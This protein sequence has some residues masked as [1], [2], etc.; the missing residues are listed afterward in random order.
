[1][2]VRRRNF[3]EKVIASL[4]VFVLVFTNFATL[5]SGLV[6]LATDS[7]D[8]NVDFSVQFVEISTNEEDNDRLEKEKEIVS[9]NSNE[10]EESNDWKE[11]SERLGDSKKIELE[12]SNDEHTAES[13]LAIELTLGVK[14]NGYLKNTKLEIKD[15]A[16]QIFKIKEDI[17]L[18]EYIQAIEENRIRLKQINSGTEVKIY[19]PVELKDETLVDIDKLQDGTKVSLIGTYVADNGDEEIITKDSKAVIG[20]SNDVNILLG[21]VV[22]KYIPYVKNGV[23]CALVQLR[24][25][26][27]S[28]TKNQLP[29]KDTTYEVLIPQIDGTTVE[30]LTVSAIN[31]A[32]TNGLSGNDVIFTPENWSYEENIVTIGVDNSSKDGKYQ[33]SLGN[34]EF[35]ISFTYVNCIDINEEKLHS[36]ILAKSNVF[37]SQGTDEK[38]SSIEKEYDLS[39]ANSNIITYEVTGKSSDMSKGYLYGNAN[40]E[41]PEYEMEFENALS[42]NISRVDLLKTVEIRE[43]AE[44]FEDE[45]GNAY[46]TSLENGSNTYYKSVRLNRENLLSIIGES[47]NLELLLEDGTSLIQVNK[48]TEDDGDGYITISFG[49]NKIDKILIRINNP[50]GEGILNIGTIKAIEKVT[51]AKNELMMFKCLSNEY[52]AVAELQ[53]GIISEMGSTKVTTTLVDTITNATISL[54]RSEISTIVENENVEINISLNN[55]LPTSDMY[56]NPVFEIVLPEEVESVDIKDINLLYGNDELEIANIETLRNGLNKIVIRVSLSGAQTKYTL[57]DSERGTTIILKTNMLL[58]MYRASRDSSAVL[59]YYNEDATNYAIGSDWKMISEPSSYMLIGRQGS[60]DDS[61]RIVAPQ[62]FVNA[63]MISNYKD[64]ESI[65]SVNQ[66][67]KEDS[68]SSFSDTRIAE[69]R[70]MLINNT[71]ENMSDVHIL[72]RTIFEGNKDIIN[73]ESLGT[74]KTAPM[75]SEIKSLEGNVQNSTIYYSENG[76]ATDSLEEESNGWTISPEDFS[77]VKSY[78]IVIDGDVEIGNV[79]MYSYDFEI[80][81]N[82]GNN[83]SLCGTFG[84]YYVGTKTVGVGEADKVVLST[85]DSPELKVETVS[86]IDESSVTEGQR[87]K[88]TVSVTN[89]GR[90]VAEGVIVNTTIPNGTTYVENGILR[91]DITDLRIDIDKIEPGKSEEVT[92]EVEVNKVVDNEVFVEADNNV[93]ANGLQTPIHTT[94][95]SVPIETAEVK[96]NLDLPRQEKVIQEND[97]F[98]YFMTVENQNEKPLENCKVVQYVPEGLTVIGAYV[99]DLEEGQ[100]GENKGIYDPSSR[101]VT[102]NINTIEKVASLKLEVKAERIEEL[103]R[104]LV[105]FAKISSDNLKNEYVSKEVEMILARP[106]LEVTYCSTSDNKYLKEGDTVKYVLQLRNIGKATARKINMENQIPS[107]LRVTGLETVKNGFSYSG[108]TGKNLSM[109]V[110]LKPGE[111]AEVVMNCVA[112]NLL[113]SVDEHITSNNW[114]ISG[115]NLAIVSTPAIEN[116]VQQNPEKVNNTYENIKIQTTDGAQEVGKDVYIN[117]SNSETVSQDNVKTYR[118]LGRAFNDMNQNGQRDDD[119]EGM[120]DIVAKLCN[121]S[122]Q[123]IVSQTVTNSIGEYLFEDVAPGEYYIKFEYDS[124]KYKVTDYK[125]NG[126]NA[127]RNSDAI[128]SNYKAVTDKIKVTNTSISDIDIGLFRAGIFDFALDANINRVIVQN[129]KETN[130]YE[131][132][133]TKLAK[134]DINP[135]YANSSNVYVEYTLTVANKGEIAGYV[136]RIVDYVPDGLT[137][138]T[139]MN[140]NWYVGADGNLYN[141]ELEDVLIRPGESKDITL[142]LTKQMSDDGTGIVN[143]TFEIEKTYNEYAVNDIDSIEGNKAQGEDDMSTADIII[144]IQTGGSLINVMIISTTL[145]TLLIAL[146][147]IKIQIDKRNKEVIV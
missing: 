74:N 63:Q 127:D 83:L 140:S 68:I 91:A 52:I 26:A 116:I 73:G 81:A 60:S 29:I 76:E 79:L 33:M 123:E 88:Y 39:Q 10:D 51:Y 108:V 131:I 54:N 58:D 44:Y 75:V 142:V 46:N 18:G 7:V 84:T 37:T 67:K 20:I 25:S 95:D 89:V 59:N 111:T 53:E 57:G 103:E 136:K 71:D 4:I 99:E 19:I 87:I 132:Q 24:V 12:E 55:A 32:Y 101:M 28:E 126:V 3:K 143:N 47:G 92:Y 13:G 65:I 139:G 135:K 70:M 31:T 100:S 130:L 105:S 36:T 128:V 62:G 50:I 9:V 93:E 41:I 40:S 48:D 133:N 98:Y 112:E 120:A 109:A 102:W 14:N 42:V 90:S 21:S 145:I 49:E 11:N 38:I 78:L 147:V 77:K 82:L 124:S 5:G 2:Q 30:G 43:S 106:E 144:G 118:I 117:E 94:T 35:I 61:L 16:N 15:L 23:N 17:S 121:A 138:D 125:K 69:M 96:I 56:K 115:E 72:G 86:D 27:C 146:Y 114:S 122:S 110:T 134:V 85:G 97:E 8:E 1:M 66:G 129:E 107:Q 22:E 141:Q 80:P 34:D 137:L 104:S 45:Y 64:G 113:N 119:E 6:S